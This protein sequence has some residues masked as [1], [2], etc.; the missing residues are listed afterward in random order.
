MTGITAQ[1]GELLVVNHFPSWRPDL[2]HERCV[3]AV[4]AAEAITRLRPD[5]AAHVVLAGD[6]DADP[7]ADSIRFW[8]GRCALASV[9]VC[10]R[11]A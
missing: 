8:T 1:F 9:S 3:Q 11:D 10:Y 7:D 2:E 6:L 5:P 4:R